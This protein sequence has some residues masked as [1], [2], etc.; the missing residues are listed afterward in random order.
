MIQ[1]LE[2]V[3][4]N[5]WSEW[6]IGDDNPTG[7]SFLKVFSGNCSV[8]FLVFG[9]EDGIPRLVVKISRARDSYTLDHEFHNLSAIYEVV[10]PFLR[11]TMPRPLLLE[12]INGHRFFVET[13]LQGQTM[14][15]L[16]HQRR[17]FR[18]RT[19]VTRDFEKAGNWI[20]CFHEE[21]KGPNII[22]G[23]KEIQEY[24]MSPMNQFVS[25]F[26]VTRKEKTFISRIC[27]EAKALVGRSVPF[28]CQQGDFWPGNI[29]LYPDSS[30]GVI[31]WQFS[32][33]YALPFL[34]LFLFITSYAT[35][36][37]TQK[38]HKKV[39]RLEAFRLTFFEKSWFFELARRFVERYCCKIGVDSDIAWFYFPVFLANIATREHSIHGDCGHVAVLD[40]RWRWLFKVYVEQEAKFACYRED[41]FDKIMSK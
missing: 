7:L 10:S 1:Q 25:T 32:Q 28:V 15:A 31:D 40:E 13:A 36:Y 3:L 5:K 38:R 2:K 39:S 26:E 35:I 30:I 12:E 9:K 18:L 27:Q 8:T 22:F 37:Q 6:F 24:I 29:L 14:F 41:S 34:D 21:T 20:T 11:Q 16:S 23:T 4:V 19:A 17:L 33:Q